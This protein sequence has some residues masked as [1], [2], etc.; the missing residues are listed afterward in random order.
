MPQE[1]NQLL[2]FH[3]RLAALEKRAEKGE[4]KHLALEKKVDKQ[5]SRLE[6]NE[7][8]V[9]GIKADI[10]DIRDDTKWLRRT[11]TAAI[12]TTVLT[13]VIGGAIALIYRLIGGG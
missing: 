3:E 6:W 11:F 9:K 8:E 10:K 1:G 12:I 13:G 2:G 4:E 5:E 7:R